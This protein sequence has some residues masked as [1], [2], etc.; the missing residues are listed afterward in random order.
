MSMA[1]V[2]A[3]PSVYN[4]RQIVGGG[5]TAAGFGLF[6]PSVI[7][8]ARPRVVV[9]G[10][11]PA[12]VIA[13][14]R[15]AVDYP[16]IDVTLIVANRHYVTPFYSNRYLAGMQA[17]DATRFDYLAVGRMADLH[18]I[19]HRVTAIE[20]DRRSIRLAE[21]SRLAYDR[22][23]LAPGI[24]LIGEAIDGY[25]K[26]AET[27]MPHAY[28]GT[29]AGQWQILHGRLTAMADGGLVVITVPPRPYRCTPAPYERA[30][31]IAGYL[32]RSKPR[33]KL[34]ILDANGTFPLMD[35]MLDAWDR[36]FGEIIEW[37]SGDFGG[38]LVAVDPASRKL[39]TEDETFTADVA[40]VIPPQRAGSLAR[41]A[42]LADESGW[43]PIDATDFSSRRADR[44]HVLGD[45]I[46]PG[47][48]PRS[49]FAA[50]AQ[51]RACAAA[52]G[53]AL[54]GRET[55]RPALEN[56]CYFLLGEGDGLVSGGRYKI[57]D[58]RITGIEG[59]SSS[60]GEDRET[61]R[62]VAR[63]GEH[64]FTDLTGEMFG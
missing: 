49:A 42:D 36:N 50:A 39:M 12:G 54:T 18:L 19:H 15:L 26:Q 38:A 41:A 44:I 25:G 51:A 45:A 9:V 60:A 13:A 31:L 30:S 1:R 24:S 48:M 56:A 29:T 22:L 43:C 14:R 28:G 57:A 8:A 64:W 6:A 59:Y 34:L 16:E 33:S 21:G 53:S 7:G 35:A 55:P 3:K 46:E 40:N 61:R 17:L 2:D 10:G 37:L 47:D 4:R 62:D 11:G 63:A 52:L 20:A 58:G 5:L 23:I 27:V 32:K